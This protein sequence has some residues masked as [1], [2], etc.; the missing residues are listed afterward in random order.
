MT[1]LD[2]RDAHLVDPEPRPVRYTVISVDDHLVEPAHLFEGRLPGRLAERAPAVV[3]QDDGREVWV[4][5]GGRYEL[6]CLGAVVGRPKEEW[7]LEPTRFDQVRPGCYDIEA[8]V[9]DMDI[10]GVWASVNFPSQITGF[11]GSVYSQCSDPALGLAVVRAWNDWCSDEWWAPHPERSIP[12]GI[13][14]LADADLAAAEI[15]RNAARGFRAVSLP[16]QPHNLGLPSLH[17]GWWDPVIEACVETETVICLHVGSSGFPESTLP[18]GAPVLQLGSTLFPV[19][20]LSSCADWLWSGYPF[21][22]PDLRIALSEG[23]IGWV[24]MLVDRLD[25]MVDRVTYGRTFTERP[26]DVLRR[27]FWFCTIDDR[28][29]IVTRDAIGIDHICVETD[30]PHGD[31]TWPDSQATL[32]ELLAGFSEEESAKVT[33]VNAAALF[34]HPLPPPGSPMAGSGPARH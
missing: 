8:R 17:T 33:H 4:F 23:G 2:H 13:T 24:A 18:P 3:E 9:K 28:S 12:M 29:T 7:T 14:F 5:D 22:H 32:V 30:Y 31:G 10:N 20:A 19:S 27:N 26:S 6:P 11:C 21:R 15:R 1:D 16:E 25:G 34:R